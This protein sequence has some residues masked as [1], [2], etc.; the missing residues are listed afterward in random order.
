M[1]A[2]RK[3]TVGKRNKT[4]LVDLVELE[5][6]VVPPLCRAWEAVKAVFLYPE[7]PR[8][9]LSGFRVWRWGQGLKNMIR[10]LFQNNHSGYRVE[11][12]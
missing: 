2:Q 1:W 7:S 3:T 10:F 12:E 9:L 6:Q 5:R 4:G 8:K 11:N